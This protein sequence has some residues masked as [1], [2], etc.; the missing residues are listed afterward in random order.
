MLSVLFLILKFSSASPL[1]FFAHGKGLGHISF[2]KGLVVPQRLRDTFSGLAISDVLNYSKTGS[3]AKNHFWLVATHEKRNV[4]I[5][6]MLFSCSIA[7]LIS[8]FQRQLNSFAFVNIGFDLLISVLNSK[9]SSAGSISVLIRRN[10][11]CSFYKTEFER[12]YQP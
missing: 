7:D 12:E 11:N 8:D 5:I 3:L 4:L 1:S 10:G 6:Q 2:K 9:F